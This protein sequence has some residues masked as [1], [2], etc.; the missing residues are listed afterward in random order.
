MP[1]TKP[2]L[3]LTCPCGRT[4]IEVVG[5]PILTASC[6]C[7]S[8]QAAG[9]QFEAAPGAPQVV[10]PDGG[11]DY[12]LYRKDRVRVA[13][14]DEYLEERR[15][16]PSSPTRRVVATCCNTPMFAD[17]TKG[18]WLSLYRDRFPGDSPPLEMRVMAKGASPSDGLPTYPAY[19]PSFMLRIMAAW[20]AMRFRRPTVTW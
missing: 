15:L 2:D 12:C 16:T 6:C 10:R 14:G 13:R 3:I 4:T 1:A 20:V 8:C 11:T 9:R 17:F 18:H 5:A 7:Q 19:P